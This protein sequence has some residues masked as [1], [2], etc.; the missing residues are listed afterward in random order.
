MILFLFI[1]VLGLAQTKKD[2]F[3]REV[4]LIFFGADYAKAQFTKADEFNNKSDILRFFVDAN[5]LIKSKWR[6]ALRWEVDRDTIGWDFSYVTMVNAAVYWQ[7][8]FSDN[9][10]YSISDEEISVMIK[11]LNIDQAKYK[12]CIGM[13]IIDENSC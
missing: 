8:V 11:D 4:T 10:D 5:N 9:I 2:I 1:S 12:D 6:N 7:K 13:I 3:N